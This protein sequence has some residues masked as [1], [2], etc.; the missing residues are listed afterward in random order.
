MAMPAVGN[1]LRVERTSIHDGGGLRTVFFLKGCPLR[2]LWCSTPESQAAEPERAYN[3]EKCTLCGVCVCTCIE[4][5]LTLDKEAGRVAVDKNRCVHAFNCAAR[6]PTGAMV[7]YGV[8]MTSTEAIREIA[9]DEIF[10]FH[11]RGGVTV[12]GGEPLEQEEFVREILLGCRERSIHQA[13][14]TSFFAA[15]ERIERLLPILNLLYVDLKHIEARRH[16]EIVGVDNAIILE[17]MQR[18]SGSACDFEMIVRLP[19][20][21]GMND[22]DDDLRRTAGFLA[23]LRKV[24]EVELLAYHRLG[25]ET[26]RNLGL[27]Y[28][29]AKI[30]IPSKE[31]MEEKAKLLATA[32]KRILIN[33]LPFEG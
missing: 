17:N 11:S 26:Y 9:K 7:R 6:C 21:P 15:W 24:K 8:K 3:S 19:L 33:G 27:E 25:T 28:P 14:E 12:S 18:A 32:G 20:I 5:A 13:M 4:S 31:Y 22:E 23:T 1:V 30:K 29:L 16:R 10:Y 2:C